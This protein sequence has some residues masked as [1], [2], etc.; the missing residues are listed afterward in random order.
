MASIND[1]SGLEPRV[2]ALVHHHASRLA[3]ANPRLEQE[4]MEQELHLHL[5]IRENDH[6]PRRGSRATFDD[7]VVRHRAADL[8]R[9]ARA[10]KRGFPAATIPLDQLRSSEDGREAGGRSEGVTASSARQESEVHW[11]DAAALRCDLVRFLAT[12]P[13]HS[14]DLCLLLLRHSVTEAARI[15]GRHRSS[16]YV[17]LA[18]LRTQGRSA[19]LDIYISPGPTDCSPSE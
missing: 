1:Y 16:I 13:S 12:R 17:W 14:R 10:S 5:H 11:E 18:A 9:D 3:A 4:D 8:A 2:V 15:I 19:G 7:R 6:D